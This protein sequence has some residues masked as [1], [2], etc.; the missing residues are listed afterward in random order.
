MNST[1]LNSDLRY[2]RAAADESVR[3]A[4][5]DE[6]GQLRCMPGRC[7]DVS[8]RRIH[9]EVPEQV[10]LQTHVALSVGRRSI[11]GPNAVKYLTKCNAKFILVLE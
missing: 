7:I 5:V 10:P 1:A 9:I 4:W 2:A 8:A 11:P 6:H 3:V